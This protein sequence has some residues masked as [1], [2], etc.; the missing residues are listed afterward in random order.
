MDKAEQQQLYAQNFVPDTPPQ[1]RTLL[2]DAFE[3]Y[4]KGSYKQARIAYEEAQKLEKAL[5]Q[6]HWKMNRRKPERKHILFYAY[7]YNALSYMA[8][9]NASKAIKEL[10]DY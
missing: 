5:Q 3:Y 9:G 4:E 7:Y 10:G 6:E 2:E 8:A 1:Q